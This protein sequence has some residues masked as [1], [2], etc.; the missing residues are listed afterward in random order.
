MR[1]FQPCALF[2]RKTREAGEEGACL[3]ASVT[4]EPG[5]KGNR[6]AQSGVVVKEPFRAACLGAGLHGKVRP[7]SEESA[8]QLLVGNGVFGTIPRDLVNRA[9]H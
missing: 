8:A 1:A 6:P 4:D 5:G 9:S 3:R 7:Q 2:S